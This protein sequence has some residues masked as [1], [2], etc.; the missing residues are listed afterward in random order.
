MKKEITS[1]LCPLRQTTEEIPHNI[2]ASKG[3]FMI[4]WINCHYLHSFKCLQRYSER[5]DMMRC[6]I[7]MHHPISLQQH[8]LEL[9]A[10]C[11]NIWIWIGCFIIAAQIRHYSSSSISSTLN[12]NT[13]CIYLFRSRLKVLVAYL[14]FVLVL[15]ST[16]QHICCKRIID[17]VSASVGLRF[18]RPLRPNNRLMLLSFTAQLWQWTGFS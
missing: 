5:L 6:K 8:L 9:W 14:V 3:M 10:D 2:Q 18:L 17:I 16:G 4:L 12:T 7:A 1:V 11:R 13:V 15:M